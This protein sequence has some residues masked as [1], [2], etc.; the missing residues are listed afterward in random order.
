MIAIKRSQIFPDHYPLFCTFND[1][2]AKTKGNSYIYKTNYKNLEKI[3]R[4]I[5]WTKYENK[6]DPN[7]T[8][9][10]LIKLLC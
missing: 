3:C 1:N 2:E 10:Y 9:E 7:M 5:E 4:K 6:D 8:I